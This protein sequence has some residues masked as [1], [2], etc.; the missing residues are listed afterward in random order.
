MKRVDLR[1]IKNKNIMGKN[2]KEILA[3]TIGVNT[4]YVE[5]NQTVYV[6]IKNAL[7]AMDE[8]VR[9]NALLDV[10]VN[11]EAECVR[12]FGE[13]GHTYCKPKYCIDYIKQSEVSV[14]P[15]CGG[16]GKLLKRGDLL[17]K[18]CKKTW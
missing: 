17:C 3:E 12:D 6:T 9:Q 7:T 18:T 16:D 13:C 15:F 2:N 11:N 10:V 4:E 5:K 8:V 1:I 14:C